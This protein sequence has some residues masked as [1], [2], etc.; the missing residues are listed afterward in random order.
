M[1]TAQ[2][3]TLL[4]QVQQLAAER[5]A[6]HWTDRQLLEEFAA[7]RSEAAFAALVAR[8]GPM[9]LRVCR[10][11]L[12]HEQDAE[13]AFQATFL[14]LATRPTA[15]R[16]RE[17]LAGWLHGV[18]YRT[19]MKAK[20]SAARRRNHEARLRTLVPASAPGPRWDDVQAAL[21]EEIQA[22]PGPSRAA[23]VLCVVG[24]KSLLEAAA[25]LGIKEGTLS[26]RLTRA[27]QRLRR[28]LARRGIRL[29]A[30][31]AALAV[32][33]RSGKGAVPASLARSA[34]RFGLLVAAG[35]PAAKVIPTH[36]A[37]LAA[38]VTRAMVV[39]KTKIAT[40]VLIVLSL[41]V[42][43]GGVLA[44][45]ALAAG[46][47]PPPAAAGTPEPKAD[48]TPPAG[49]AGAAATFG[50]RVLDPE[51]KPFGG[52]RLHLIGTIWS[53]P[54]PVH[55]QATSAADGTFRLPVAP[56]DARRL[57]DDAAWGTTAVVATAD[58]Y[59]PAFHV[60][61]FEPTANLTL[62]LV[63]DDVPVRGRVLDLQGRPLAGVTVRVES[64]S[65]S[66]AG[67][68]T[69]WLAALEANK[70]DAYP[71]ESR[72]LEQVRLAETPG[73]YSAVVTDAGGR[74]QL[75]GVG[76]E[77]VVYLVLE[78]PTIARQ[79]LTVYTRPGKAIHAG[80]F[81]RNPDGYRLTYYGA[82]FDHTAAP[83][84]PIVGL[85]RD[86]DTGKPLA[87]VTVQSDRFAGNNVHGDSSVRTVTAKDGHYRLVGMP[88]GVGN[89]LKAAPAPGQPYFQSVHEVEDSPGLEPVT[90]D[91]ALTRGVLVKGR[92][93]DKASGRPVFANVGYVVFRDNPR[94]AQAP[95]FATDPYLETAD[96]GSFQLVAF[97]GRGL[98]FA[99][100]WSDHYRMGVGTDS[101]KGKLK[102]QE[103]LELFD[104]VPHLQETDTAHTYAEINPAD[105]AE[106]VTCD[107][108]LD[109]GPMPHGT[110]AGPD[111]KPLSGAQALG[112]TAY[113]RW[114][115]WTRAPLKS[116]AFT[117][118][119]LGPTEER[120]L[121]FVHTAKQLAGAV[122]VRG[123]A[124]EPLSVKLEP[125][126][127]V[128]GRLVG[129][130]GTPRAGLLLQG[131]DRLLPGTSLQTGKDGRF[132]VAGLAPGVA[133]SLNLVRNGQPTAAVFAGLTL[134]PAEVRDLGNVVVSEK[135]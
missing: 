87:G 12:R 20:R 4:G 125:W 9:V 38:G 78:G 17:V 73:L 132:R 86:R 109:P 110:L 6:A 14:V 69:P 2:L 25:E 45:Q 130:D 18:A 21:D 120:E 28:Q 133:Y 49:E 51:G 24:G 64:L 122:R 94:P 66:A 57:S 115:S 50:G 106:S 3:G 53:R 131:D 27:R 114:R 121:V 56:A 80:A 103:K 79:R 124:K 23:F 68:L 85:V 65:T 67:D 52:A 88:K 29:A 97:P 83:T 112:L 40:A 82:D 91:F 26:S 134:K 35:E 117:V 90:V 41:L 13:D 42:A 126:G 15:I 8:H 36:V 16:Q 39:T 77:R 32:A 44:Y 61:N 135:K 43:A 47:E 72:Y 71:I 81:A 101:I 7:R 119:G 102:L 93:L 11:V 89:I 128:T 74:F 55:V 33:E 123:D 62:R 104:T 98:L 1:A 118:Y 76:C 63:K 100:G 30:L 95:G 37:A 92:V 58:G 5:C 46:E 84:R 113:N 31:L 10:R 129:P 75:K 116:E 108:V 59:G 54:S 34:V 99:R 19:A 111:G 127:T 48:T 105:K 22:L 107:L 70:Q 60:G 96:D